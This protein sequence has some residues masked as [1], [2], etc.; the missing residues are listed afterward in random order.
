VNGYDPVFL[1]EDEEFDYS[2]LTILYIGH[3]DNCKDVLSVLLQLRSLIPVNYI[4][5]GVVV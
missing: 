5:N 1:K 4:L 2:A 3:M